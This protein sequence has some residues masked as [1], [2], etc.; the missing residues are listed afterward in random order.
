MANVI[1]NSIGSRPVRASQ[2]GHKSQ[3]VPRDV[4]F[5]KITRWGFIYHMQMISVS[6]QHT[7]DIN[8]IVQPRSNNQH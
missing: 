7:S 3:H 2:Q 4:R 5:L 8:F 6:L 1:S